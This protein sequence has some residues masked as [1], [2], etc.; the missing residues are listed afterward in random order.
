MS[1][2]YSPALT[3]GQEVCSYVGVIT[4]VATSLGMIIQIELIWVSRV[5]YQGHGIRN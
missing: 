2:S 1:R 4:G 3:I 5:P